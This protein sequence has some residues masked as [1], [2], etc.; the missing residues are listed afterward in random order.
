MSHDP[1]RSDSHHDG[2]GPGPAYA[3]AFIALSEHPTA[4]RGPT[5]LAVHQEPG[6]RA[7]A[8][9]SETSVGEP[10]R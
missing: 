7:G 1:P 4:D 5:G 10:R 6:R 8:G 3:G 9:E 2:Q